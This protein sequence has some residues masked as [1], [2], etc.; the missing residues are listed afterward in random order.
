MT[1]ELEKLSHNKIKAHQ[2]ETSQQAEVA[3]T[4]YET[5]AK[6]DRKVESVL[7]VDHYK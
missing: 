2:Q 6:N 4:G 3:P 1:Q 5:A 7:N